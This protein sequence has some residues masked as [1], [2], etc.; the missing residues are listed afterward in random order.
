MPPS[1]GDHALNLPLPQG[2]SARI[3]RFRERHAGWARRPMRSRPHVSIKGGAGLSDDRRCLE[4]IEAIA[5][6]T[7][8]F[9]VRLGGPAV[10]PDG[11]GVLHLRVDAPGWGRLP[12]GCSHGDHVAT[13]PR[14]VSPGSGI[15]AAPP[16]NVVWPSS[17]G[18]IE[19]RVGDGGRWG[20]S[21]VAWGACA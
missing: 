3:E 2:L 6:A 8:P 5:G 14:H 4:L 12:A 11:G 7:P 21:V 18:G 16:P 19:V 17:A 9:P 15:S 13:G 1:P 10:F 20:R